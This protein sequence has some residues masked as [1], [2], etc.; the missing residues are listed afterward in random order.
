MVKV[1]GGSIH[2]VMNC[3]SSDIVYFVILKNLFLVIKI[4]KLGCTF[5]PLIT[6]NFDMFMLSVLS[7][8]QLCLINLW[9]MIQCSVLS[10]GV[11][12]FPALTTAKNSTIY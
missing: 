2:F 3:V 6:C 12:L 11:S 10:T 5:L 7:F 1:I 4:A 8:Y 9:V